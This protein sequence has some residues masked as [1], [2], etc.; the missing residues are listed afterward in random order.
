MWAYVE[1]G[2]VHTVYKEAKTFLLNG[3]RYPSNMFNLW[4]DSEKEAIGIYTVTQATKKDDN[5]YTIGNPSYSFNSGTKR[6]T[7]SYSP[8]ART[9]STVKTEQTTRIK[10]IAHSL[11]K[12]YRWLVERKIYTDI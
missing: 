2:N 1:G 7:E 4:T 3:V 8:N 5:Y 9:L 10:N 12:G 11:I 6:V